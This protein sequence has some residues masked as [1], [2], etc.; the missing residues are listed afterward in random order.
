M[1]YF[2]ILTKY[3]LFTR[4]AGSVLSCYNRWPVL[5]HA[6]AL[7]VWVINGVS[8]PRSLFQHNMFCRRAT[9]GCFFVCFFVQVAVRLCESKFKHFCPG[10]Y[11]FLSAMQTSHEFS[12]S[13]QWAIDKF[14][15]VYIYYFLYW[16]WFSLRAMVF[17]FDSFMQQRQTH[18]TSRHFYYFTQY[19]HL[20]TL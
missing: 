1:K 19:F 2:C 11:G 3:Q 8:T 14:S 9:C 16:K 5:H 4:L 15:N 17:N 7:L 10:P 13:F 20:I 18:L 12:I 6:V